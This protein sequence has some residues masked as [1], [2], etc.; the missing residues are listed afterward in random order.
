MWIV[1]WLYYVLCSKKPKKAQHAHYAIRQRRRRL[2]GSGTYAV[3][4]IDN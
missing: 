1:D 4:V 3:Y 2:D